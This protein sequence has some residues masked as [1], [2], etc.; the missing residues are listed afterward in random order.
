MNS[1]KEIHIPKEKKMK[2]TR[3]DNSEQGTRKKTAQAPIAWE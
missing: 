3:Q 2:H 1:F